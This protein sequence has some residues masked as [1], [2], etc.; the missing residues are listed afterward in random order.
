MRVVDG[1]CLPDG[2]EEI[3]HVAECRALEHPKLRL[4]FGNGEERETDLSPLLGRPAFRPL[5]DERVFRSFALEH[6]IVT[7]P[8]VDLDIAPEW[9]RDHGVPCRGDAAV[10]CVAEP[11]PGGYGE[12]G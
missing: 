2:R 6:G 11:P 1:I 7:W 9:L 4:R 3:L 5:A 8:G 12:R 10:D